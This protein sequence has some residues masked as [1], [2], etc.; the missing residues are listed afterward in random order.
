VRR[1]EVVRKHSPWAW[2]WERRRC[3]GVEMGFWGWT[4]YIMQMTVDEIEIKTKTWNQISK[5]KIMKPK[6]NAKN[7]LG[8]ARISTRKRITCVWKQNG[9]SKPWIKI[10][11]NVVRWRPSY[12][13]GPFGLG[14]RGDSWCCFQICFRHRS[15]PKPGFTE[16]LYDVTANVFGVCTDRVVGT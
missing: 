8:K 15:C 7:S 12:I 9:T 1:D 11:G 10:T 2:R 5:I 6:L 14:F 4:F 13:S 3:W 16:P